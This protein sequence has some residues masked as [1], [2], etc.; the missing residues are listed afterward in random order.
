MERVLGICGDDNQ[1][2]LT[3]PR[4]DMLFGL[5]GARALQHLTAA[6]VRT[7]LGKDVYEK[8]F[9]F[10]FIRNPYDRA[11]STYHI[12]Q[13]LLPRIKMSFR[14]FVLKRISGRRRFVLR[15]LFRSTAEKAL[16]D[17]FGDQHEF[18]FDQNEQSLVDFI[19]RYENLE[20]DFKKIC[21]RLGIKA[22]LPVM[23]Q[24]R[25]EGYKTYYDE[26][27]RRAISEIYKKDI[28]TFGYE[29]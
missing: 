15:N 6:D 28:Q 27:T 29:F 22:D 3:P 21:D 4:P 5:V 1:G 24:S 19:G 7:K 17:Q 2:T 16:E 12:R 11:V 18:I 10:A 8:Y 14:D 9:K 20:A 23:N 26:D 25:H 13:K